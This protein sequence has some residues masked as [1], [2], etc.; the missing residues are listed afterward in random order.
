MKFKKLSGCGFSW[1]YWVSDMD[2]S[3][4][5]GDFINRKPRPSSFVTSYQK[6][7]ESKLSK[8]KRISECLFIIL[9]TET[10]GVSVKQDY[11]ISYG[12][13]KIRNYTIKINSSRQWFLKLKKEGKEAITVHEI[14]NVKN[15]LSLRQFVKQFLNDIGNAV[16]VGHHIDFDIAMLE[17]AARPFGLKKLLNPRLDTQNL[18][19][20]LELGKYADHQLVNKKD[21]SLDAL[22][23]RYH[24][25]LDDRHTAAGDAFLTAQLFLKLLKIAEQKGIRILEDLL[26]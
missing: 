16:I 8:N 10:T 15:A 14:I 17:K 13:V 25:S 24:I 18:A 11:I 22:C 12:S 19:A 6:C 4:Y 26:A 2:W 9:D 21:Y 20:R 23:Q 3:D 1:I 7:F 5:F